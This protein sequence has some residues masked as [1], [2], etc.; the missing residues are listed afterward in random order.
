MATTEQN[1]QATTD[2]RNVETGQDSDGTH[3]TITNDSQSHDQ[4][5]IDDGQVT[6]T[7]NESSDTRTTGQWPV[8]ADEHVRKLISEAQDEREARENIRANHRNLNR[9]L[10][11]IGALIIS[12]VVT[13]L[14][15]YD[16]SLPLWAHKLAPFSFAITILMDSSFVLYS[17]IRHY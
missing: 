11:L 10:T 13:W 3:V 15:Y 6:Y 8:E 9:L 1:G 17:Y 4:T 5:N 7:A 2:T 14:L 12:F 16:P